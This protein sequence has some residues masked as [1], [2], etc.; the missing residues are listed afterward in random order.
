MKRGFTSAFGL[1]SK[2]SKRTRF[3]MDDDSDNEDDD[4]GNVYSFNN[5]IYFYSDVTPKSCFLLIKELKKVTRAVEDLNRKFSVDAKIHL[6]I[7]SNGGCVHSAFGV[8]DMIKTNGI[9]V[10]T[11][12]EGVAASAGT[13]I[14]MVG[15]H[16]F[17]TE[18]SYM[19]I[20]QL[21]T[22]LGGKMMEIEDE[23][24]NTKMVMNRIK[25]L[26]KTYTTFRVKELEDL[27]KHDLLLDSNKCVSSGLADEIYK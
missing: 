15:K 17:I 22:F 5:H 26:Y 11:Y 9:D 20:H 12:V 16:R 6:H 3:V 8:I 7:N 10:Y 2:P 25:G 21:S 14:S 27:L 4:L 23:Y 13:I 19:L 1:S 18:N 24:K